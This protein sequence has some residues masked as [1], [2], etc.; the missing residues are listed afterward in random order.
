MSVKRGLSVEVRAG[1]KARN[2]LQAH[3]CHGCGY[4]STS[5]YGLKKHRRVC[6][7]AGGF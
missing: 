1:S 6:D 2:E 4:V 5:K 7:K 3:T